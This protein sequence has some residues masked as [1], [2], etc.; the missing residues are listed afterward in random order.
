MLKNSIYIVC[1]LFVIVCVNAD[2]QAAEKN[3]AAHWSLDDGAGT[4]AEDIS[5]NGNHGKISGKV[6]WVAGKVGKALDCDGSTSVDCGWAASLNIPQNITTEY[7]IKPGVT[8]DSKGKR[9]NVLYM[10]WGPMFAF[11]TGWGAKGALTQWYDGP[12]P[13]PTIHSKT[14]EWEKDKWYYIVAVYDGSASKL[15]V[16]AKEEGSIKCKGDIKKREK[17]LVFG[18]KYVGIIDEVK[19]YSLAKSAQEIKSSYEDP[20]AAVD[21][22]GKL[23]LTWGQLKIGL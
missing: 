4:T 18:P 19:V 14:T 17:S 5:G 15:Y 9:V 16:N 23:T 21:A 20:T 22:S 6:K 7:W 10:L 8:I 3:L 13:K 2:V 11:N 1:T 12:S